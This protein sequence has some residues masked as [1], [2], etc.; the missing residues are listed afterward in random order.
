MATHVEEFATALGELK[1]RSGRSYGQLATRLHLSTSTLHR[2][3]N[4]AAVPTEYAP[5]ERLARLC[6]ATPQ[7]LVALHRLW[8]LADSSRRG[9]DCPEPQQ[10]VELEP[11]APEPITPA[12]RPTESDTPPRVAVRARRPVLLL[13]AASVIAAVAVLPLTLRGATD[14]HR[15]GASV[16]NA[17]PTTT[18]TTVLPGS[19]TPSTSTT[20]TPTGTGTGTASASASA[21]QDPGAATTTAPVQVTVLTDNWGTQCGQWYL[22][23]RQPDKVPQPPPLDQTNAW[24][25]E[26]DAIPAGHLRLQ[27]TA[28]SLPGQQVVLHALYVHVVTSKPAP[29]GLAYEPFSGCGGPLEPAAF[30]V[31][32]DQV[33]PRTKPVPGTVGSSDKPT[34]T[35]FPYQVSTGDPEVLDVDASTF[36]QDVTWYL[37]LLWSSGDRQG[38]LRID[39]HGRPFHTVG[40]KGDPGYLY[41]GTAWT[42]TRP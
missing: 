22:T 6:G 35:N 9:T 25:A 14:T 7:E 23:M 8:L 34:L 3:C 26:L 38:S 24:A 30:A 37:E 31:D 10:G 4:G 36:G 39:D 5:V 33:A 19:A 40:L 21:S 20:A 16:I 11:A 18:G 41:N 42:P 2:Y 13:G 28:Q 32:L 17:G 15:T 27:L 1:E 29:R 12:P